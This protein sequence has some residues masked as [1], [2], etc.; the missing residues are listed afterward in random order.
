MRGLVVEA[1]A[2]CEMR[3]PTWGQR[4]QPPTPRTKPSTEHHQRVRYAPRR[5]SWA[6]GRW[7]GFARAATV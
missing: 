6:S 2:K 4:L 1:G 5:E 7:A 3:S